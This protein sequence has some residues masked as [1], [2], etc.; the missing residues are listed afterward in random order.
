M[1]RAI[2]TGLFDKV[3][4]RQGG[5]GR[6]V[7]VTPPHLERVTGDS[8]WLDN[9]PRYDYG[10]DGKLHHTGT[11]KEY[12]WTHPW[13]AWLSGARPSS[14]SCGVSP[15]RRG[16]R[17]DEALCRPDRAAAGAGAGALSARR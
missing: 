15:T 3:C 2:E 7:W 10:A 16:A 5:C 11:F 6:S 9:A 17:A 4:R 12:R 8:S 1:V 14:A 13:T